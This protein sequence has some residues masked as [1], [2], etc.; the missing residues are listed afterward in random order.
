MGKVISFKHKGN[1]SKTEKF[2]LSNRQCSYEDL[3]RLYGDMGVEA[4][5]RATPIST[6]LTASSWD[7]CIEKEKNAIRIVWINRNIHQ[8]ANIAIL[9]QY[10]HGTGTG[11]WVEGVDYINPAMRPV[12]EALAEKA[13]KAVTG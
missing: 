4:L 8:G 11:G 1:F 5:E 10:G 9:L 7:Y 6:G 13:W 12:F 2:L 3:L